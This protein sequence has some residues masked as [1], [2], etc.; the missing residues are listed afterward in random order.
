[1]KRGTPKIPPAITEII[2]NKKATLKNKLF[3]LTVKHEQLSDEIR[4][5]KQY[6]SP[7]QLSILRKARGRIGGM[8]KEVKKELQLLG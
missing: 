3:E 6:R 4:N 7:A 2:Q 5:K 1:M 8:I